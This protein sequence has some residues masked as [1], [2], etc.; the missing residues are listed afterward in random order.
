MPKR[1]R[2]RPSEG[3][4]DKGS[5][6]LSGSGLGPVYFHLCPTCHLSRS[7]SDEDEVRAFARSHVSMHRA[8][9]SRALRGTASIYVPVFGA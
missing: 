1:R 6:S 8:R 3:E 5:S 9:A 2:N 7:S 4:P